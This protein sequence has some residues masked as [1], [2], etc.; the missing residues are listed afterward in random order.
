M[1]N[2]KGRLMKGD[3]LS[4]TTEFKPGQEHWRPWKSCRVKEIL[5]EQAARGLTVAE[6]AKESGCTSANIH[7]WLKRHGLMVQKRT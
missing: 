1:P 5:R 7:Y 2:E 6:M 3:H 4:P